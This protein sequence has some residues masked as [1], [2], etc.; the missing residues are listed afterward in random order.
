MH[1]LH[2]KLKDKKR[3]KWFKIREVLVSAITRLGVWVTQ[4][5]VYLS[6]TLNLV[7]LKL[8]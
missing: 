3:E 4:H 1:K 8:L 7:L 6:S 5:R 2:Q